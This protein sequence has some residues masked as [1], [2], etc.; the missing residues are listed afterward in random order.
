MLC[1]AVPCCAM[2]CPLPAARCRALESLSPSY[3]SAASLAAHARHLMATGTMQGIF[4]YAALPTSEA[5]AAAAGRAA[6]YPCKGAPLFS[7]QLSVQ[8]GRPSLATLP[9]PYLHAAL[10]C[11]PSTFGKY[12]VLSPLPTG[13]RLETRTGVTTYCQC[14]ALCRN[15][16][17]ASSRTCKRQDAAALLALRLLCN[18]AMPC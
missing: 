17:G 5:A 13:W 16:L 9:L 1:H 14:C 10:P 6:A 11:T 3:E 15:Y 12:W 7:M 18:G 4:C 8:P 2:L